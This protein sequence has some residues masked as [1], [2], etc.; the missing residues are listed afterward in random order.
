MLQIIEEE[1]LLH[2]FVLLQEVLDRVSD[3]ACIV[4]DSKLYRPQ[5]LV[6]PLDEVLV[7]RQFT[8]QLLQ[9]SLVSSLQRERG[10]REGDGGGSASG[11]N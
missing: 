11:N 6:C 8:V 7:A 3:R 9:E 5:P 4:L 2:I 1:F 10:E